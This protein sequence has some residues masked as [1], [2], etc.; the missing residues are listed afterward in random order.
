MILPG[1]FLTKHGREKTRNER[2]LCLLTCLLSRAVHLEKTF[3]LNTTRFLNWFYRMV[4]RRGVPIEV[5]TDN[6][7]CFVAINKELKKLVSDLDEEKIKQATSIQKMKWHFNPPFSPYF[8][9]IFEII[10]KPA[11]REVYDQFKNPDINDEELLSAFAGAEVLINL[12]TL[13][14]Q[15]VDAHDVSPVTPNHFLFGQLGGQFA[16][17]VEVRIYYDAEDGDIFN[18]W[19]NTSGNVRC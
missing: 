6:S 14:Y 2:Y 13:I 3:G 1:H 8:G 7:G 11:K 12:K 18:S 16:P 15:S 19:F 17:E 10:I 4:N 5:I 9:G